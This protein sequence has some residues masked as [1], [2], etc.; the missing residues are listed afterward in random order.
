LALL[1]RHQAHCR[2]E[3]VF[4]KSAALINGTNPVGGQEPQPDPPARPAAA[5]S[6]RPGSKREVPL[7]RRNVK[8]KGELLTHPIKRALLILIEDRKLLHDGSRWLGESQR[9]VIFQTIEAMYS[10]YLIKIVIDNRHRRRQVAMLTE[11]GECVA[12]DLLRGTD[13]VAPAKISEDAA[14]F[15]AE[16][17]A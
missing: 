8:R 12:R 1:P 6:I 17:V 14:R 10:R 3:I 5:P 4:M 16:A 9:G 7:G 11:I 2:E 15:I 13:I